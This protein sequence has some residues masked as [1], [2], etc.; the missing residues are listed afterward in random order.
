M[1][2][3]IGAGLLIA[4]RANDPSENIDRLNARL[5]ALSEIVADGEKNARSSDLVKLNSDASILITGDKIAIKNATELAGV[6]GKYKDAI[7]AE[8]SKETL[9]S[10]KQAAVDGRFDRE[11]KKVLSEKLVSTQDL[12]REVNSQSAKTEVKSTTK[13]A[14]AHFTTIYESLKLLNL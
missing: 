9:A 8:S 14:H 11:Y 7:A 6:T 10:L 1:L 3:I 5:K 12:L 4:T 13:N 2:V